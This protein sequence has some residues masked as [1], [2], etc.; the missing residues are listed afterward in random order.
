MV[1]SFPVAA[2]LALFLFLCSATVQSQVPAGSSARDIQTEVQQ[3][4]PRVNQ[5][6]ER[7][8]D[9]FRKGVLDLADNKRAQA[10]DE[11]DKAVDTILMSGMDVRSSQRLQTYYLELVERIYREEVKHSPPA[12]R[13]ERIKN[14]LKSADLYI[15]PVDPQDKPSDDG[16]TIKYRARK[17]DTIAK[18]AARHK[19]S[20]NEVSR[21]N[22][23]AVDAELQ[24]GQEIRLR[25]TGSQ[26][27][28]TDL[29]IEYLKS[30]REYK[31]SLE[32]LLALYQASVRKAEQRLT[33][34]KQ[35]FDQKMIDEAER[36]VTDA[37]LKVEGVRKQ[38]ADTDNQ[39]NEMGTKVRQQ[40]NARARELSQELNEAVRQEM[41]A[42]ELIGPKPPQS[43]NG[44]MPIVI[45]WFNEH[46][47][48][49]YSA[50]YVSWTR[51]RKGSH[52]GAPY[53][54]V[55]VRV[56]AKNAFNAYRLSDYVFYIRHNR[57]VIYDAGN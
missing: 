51:V 44:T 34:S 41:R 35:L 52:N 28:L 53:W 18:I 2:I 39:L 32:K 49:P 33:E 19:L 21:L 7:A 4:E 37:K 20:S 6:I 54:I 10:R 55:A 47:H 57:V 31:E 29:Q 16:N 25:I 15:P 8:N 14:P 45:K 26:D 38:I 42:A 23:I 11:F 9:H 22:G 46:L 5:I 24:A 12:L 1:R 48:D 43:A 30:T 40:L 36:A 3:N 17:G 27:E 50:R 56:R 13:S